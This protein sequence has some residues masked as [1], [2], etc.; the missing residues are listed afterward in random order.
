MAQ[1]ERLLKEFADLSTQGLMGAAVA[2]SF[3]RRL[4]HPIQERVHPT[5]E[6]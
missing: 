5:F 3:C 1:V 4:T 2:I 6:Y